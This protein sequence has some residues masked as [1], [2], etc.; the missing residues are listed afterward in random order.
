[1]NLLPKAKNWMLDILFPP[2]CLNCKNTL[3]DQEKEGK[4]CKKC[5]E[6]IETYSSFFCPKC[7]SRIPSE[8]KICHKEIKFLLAPVTDYQNP[9]VKNLIWFLKY[10]KWQS[11]VQTIKPLIDGYLDILSMG[12]RNDLGDFIVMPIPLHSDRLK[13]RGFNQ[14]DLLADIVSQKTNTRLIRNNLKRIKATKN[15]AELKN[16]NERIIN[17]ENCFAL[18]DPKEIENKNIILVDDVFTSGSTMGEA[19]KVLKNAGAKKIIAFVFA[20]A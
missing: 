4:I 17:I 12:Q 3:E 5:L 14:S 8:Q 13:E 18:N 20:K 15:Q 11:I 6:S 16:L 19:V 9:P 1:M 10:H 2:I 7:K